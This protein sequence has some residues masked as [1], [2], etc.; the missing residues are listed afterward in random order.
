MNDVGQSKIESGLELAHIGYVVTNMDGAL[1]RFV[2]EGAEVV[3]T[4][5]HD[6]VQNVHVAV[7][8]LPGQ[9]AI[10]LVAPDDSGNSPVK[11]RLDRGGGL[12]HLCYFTDDIEAAVNHETEQGAVVVCDPVFAVAFNATVAFVHRRTGLVVEYMTRPEAA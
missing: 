5:C 4:P 7:V 3:L 1:K 12:D 2:R 10:E 11:A 6:P 9:V 8:E